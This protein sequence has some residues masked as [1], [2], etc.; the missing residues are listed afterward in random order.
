MGT[1]CV[2]RRALVDVAI[3][4][5]GITHIVRAS[6]RDGPKLGR[7]AIIGRDFL[8]REPFLIRIGSGDVKT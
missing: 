8:A 4:Y 2:E 3:T 7:T 1:D 6:V 5:R